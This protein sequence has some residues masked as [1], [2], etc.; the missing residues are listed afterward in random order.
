MTQ[1]SIESEVA[2]FNEGFEAQIGPDLARTFAR[3]QAD[4]R[5]A[6]APA[7]VV[8]DGDTLP[9][10]VLLTAG[11]DPVRLSAVLGGA[12]AVIVFYRGAWCPYCN[13]T[14]RAYQRELLPVLNERGITL[15]AVSPQHPERSGATAEGAELGFDVLSDPSNALAG[16]LGIVT[17]PSADARLAHTELGFE[18]SD[19]NADGT[20]SI[21]FPTVLVV[22][23]GG[24]VR[25]ADVHTDYTKRTEAADIVAALAGL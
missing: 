14:L 22:D 5:S 24:T 6:G 9:D 15:L 11:G 10:A 4:L 1:A 7:G 23:A 13:I 21:P 20:A 17:E 8:T 2:L 16:A 25:F 12:P 3:E 19:S 18:V